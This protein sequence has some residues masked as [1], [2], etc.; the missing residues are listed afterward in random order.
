M[1]SLLLSLVPVQYRLHAHLKYQ[2]AMQ[3][4]QLTRYM[5]LKLHQPLMHSN[6]GYVRPLRVDEHR[7]QAS[8]ATK[9]P[10]AVRLTVPHKTPLARDI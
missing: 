2:D 10:L 7:A 8:A 4:H 1:A 5:V 9:N 3:T 6:L